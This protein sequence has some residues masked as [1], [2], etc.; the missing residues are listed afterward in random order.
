[1]KSIYLTLAIIA[2][3]V[4]AKTFFFILEE[5]QQAII[6][7]FGKP[8]GDPIVKPGIH[9]KTPYLHKTIFL[10]KRILLWDGFPNQIPTKDKKF[11]SV[12]TTARWRIVDPLKFLQTVRTEEGSKDKL[13]SILDGATR[14]AISSHN[15]VEAVRNSNSIIEEVAKAK[16]DDIESFESAGELEKIEIGRESLSIKIAEEANKR[17]S[18]LGIEVIDVQLRRVS[19]EKSVEAKVYDRMRSERKRIA[20]KIR[21]IGRAEKAII[22]GRLSKELQIIEA[23]SYRQAEIIKGKAEAESVSIY[24][25]SLKN[26]ADLYDFFRSMEAYKKSLKSDTKLILSSDSEFLKYLKRN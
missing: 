26:N 11:I 19:Y 23:N 24:A 25:K 1:M 12:D 6:T 22:E 8:V 7:Q 10:E 20:E 4:S 5:G 13:D 2:I 3:L 17:V 21:S 15:L 18:D 16:T 9:F 14:N